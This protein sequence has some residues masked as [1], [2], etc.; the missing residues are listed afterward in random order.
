MKPAHI[1][2]EINPFG[3]SLGRFYAGFV[4][5]LERAAG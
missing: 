4:F 1:D 3:S 5:N 2:D